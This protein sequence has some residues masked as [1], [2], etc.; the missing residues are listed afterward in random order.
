MKKC[1]F[2]AEQILD[3]AI[4]CRYCGEFLNGS[5]PPAPMPAGGQKKWTQSTGV[6]VL[7]L[8]TV[9]PFALP[10]VWARPQWSAMTKTVI[11]AAVLLATAA[12]V[13]LMVFL[14]KFMFGRIDAALQGLGLIG[15]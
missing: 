8:L 1:P 14:L 13:G 3:E 10:L 15:F 2:C 7:G 11:T 12:L 4:K 6:I 9:G 5:R